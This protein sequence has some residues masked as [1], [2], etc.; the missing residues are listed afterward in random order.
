MKD[1]IVIDNLTNEQLENVLAYLDTNDGDLFNSPTLNKRYIQVDVRYS[2]FNRRNM[3]KLTIPRKWISRL[4]EQAT[5]D[6]I[7]QGMLR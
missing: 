7:R 1:N 6:M 3:F 2:R 5:L 4:S